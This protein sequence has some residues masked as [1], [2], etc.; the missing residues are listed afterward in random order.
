MPR[1]EFLKRGGG[2]LLSAYESVG[3]ALKDAFPDFPW[4]LSRF[5]GG[6]ATTR[7]KER[8][9]V[10]KELEKAEER[11]NIQSVSFHL[12]YQSLL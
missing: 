8:E 1:R 7:W 12:I 4:Q 2:H 9:F 5:I 6:V 11:L 3:H 10:M